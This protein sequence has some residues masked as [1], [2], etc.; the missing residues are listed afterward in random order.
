MSSNHVYYGS[1]NTKDVQLTDIAFNKDEFGYYLS[2][3][4]KVED[5][6]SIREVNVPKIRLLINPNQL[7]LRTEADLYSCGYRAWA[8]LGFGELPMEFETV[9]GNK[10]LYTETILEE[11]YA[12]MTLDEIEKKLGHKIK[13]VS[14]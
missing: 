12:E 14:K 11:K 10:V 2:T 4:F 7:Y 5:E 1:M 13:I 8:N 9:D 3:K 6:H